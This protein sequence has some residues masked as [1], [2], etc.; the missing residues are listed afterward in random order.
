MTGV[1]HGQ[2]AR[3][4][5]DRAAIELLRVR[6]R[7]RA[8]LR[9]VLAVGHA[10]LALQPAKPTYN[11]GGP[12]AGPV[13]VLLRQNAELKRDLDNMVGNSWLALATIRRVRALT[14]GRADHDTIAVGELRE[15][16]DDTPDTQE[17]TA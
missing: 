17:A 12:A 7:R 6:G 9:A 3:K 16:L 11:D 10:L 15:A 5:L 1:D 14:A 2:V 8:E 13:D 4:H